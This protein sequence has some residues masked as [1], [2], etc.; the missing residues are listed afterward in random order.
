M[1]SAKLIILNEFLVGIYFCFTREEWSIV[2]D[3]SYP[4]I[5]QLQYISNTWYLIARETSPATFK[6]AV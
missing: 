2:T 5:A 3:F 6:L 1:A 4:N